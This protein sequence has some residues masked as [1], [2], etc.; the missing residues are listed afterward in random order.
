[1][2]ARLA[3][4]V[5]AA[6]AVVAIGLGAPPTAAAQYGAVDGEWRSYAG[7]PGSTKYSPLDQIDAGNFGD[8]RIA[9]RWASVDADVDLEAVASDDERLSILGLQA[10]PLMIDG[11]LYLSTALYQAAAVDAGTGETVWVHDPQAYLGGRPTHA[12]RSRGVAYWSE[13]DGSDARI[14]WGTSE[15]YLLAVD[16][17]TGEPIRDFGDDGRVDLMEGIPRAV[18]GETNYQGR[19][20]IGVASPP[21]IARDVVLTPTIV[22]DFVVRRE[23]PPGWVKG[24]DARTGD[25]KWVFR[26]VP[27]GDDFGADTWQNESWRYSGNANIWPPLSSDEE[28]GMFYL[29]TGTPTSDYYGGHR[30]G[31]NLFAE[32][33]VAVDAETGARVWHFQAVHHGVWDYDFPAAPTLLDIT[34]DGRRIKALAQVSKQGFTYVFDR[35][36]GEPV[37]PIEE[38]AVE[39]DT[40]LPGEVL[41]PTQ[42]FPTKPPPFEYQGIGIDDLVD[43]TPEIRQMAIEAVENFRLG[44]L[45]TPP[46][47]TVEGGL[48]GTIQRPHIAGGASWSGAAADP[49]TG[50]LYVSSEN[51]FSVLKYYTPDPDEGGNLDFTQADFDSGTQPLMPRGLPL[52]KPPYSRMTAIDLN[53]GDHAWMQPNG[54]GERYRRHPMLR[55][56]DLPPLGGEGHG[57]PLLTKTLLISA[58]SAGGSDR[59]P[60]LV[61]RDK[62]TGAIVA[63]VDLPAGAIGTPMTYLHEGR[64]YIAL[65]IGGD[66]PQLIALA[67]PQES[68]P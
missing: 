36:T 2:S 39:T 50:L 5:T 59:G 40:D 60:R 34:V 18:R 22:S 3:G 52:L 62:A 29:P 26:T 42:P 64:Q 7:D 32:S 12:Y 61:A 56:L 17:R 4:L 49:E 6:V 43:F 24:V 35:A 68:A 58:L 1:M 19:N 37:W 46:M 45:F 28:L 65:T 15:A 47:L 44:P 13:D 53:A 38:L 14:F 63:S 10:T 23:A 57:G 20:L 11:V 55:D 27:L 31:D 33:I 21:A 8:L 41:S 30:L 48:Q 25:V 67:L 16:A 51:R 9:W 54:D 66:V